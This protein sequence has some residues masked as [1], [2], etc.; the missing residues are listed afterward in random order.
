MTTAANGWGAR[1]ASQASELV[2]LRRE[3]DE[4]NRGVLALFAEVDA[5]FRTLYAKAPSGICLLD[6]EGRFTDANPAL[7]R[8]LRLDLA[9]VIGKRF[10]DVAPPD[11]I[12]W[13]VSPLAEAGMSMA[14][15][16]DVSQRVS[17]EKTR[18]ELLAREQAA[19]REAERVSL[20]KDDLIA[21]LSHELRTPLNAIMGWTHVLLR[22]GGNEDMQRGLQAIER[23]GKA[24][25]RLISDILDVSS[26]NLGKLHL[27]LEPC[28]PGALVRSALEEMRGPVADGRIEL[29]TTLNSAYRPIRADPGRI[30]QIVW[31]LVSNAIKFCSPGGRIE[32]SLVETERE[33]QLSVADDGQGIDPRFLP[34]LFDRFSQG[35]AASTRSR[36]GLGLGLS[37]VRHLVQLHHGTISASSP[38]I[39]FGSK[40]EI[41]LPALLGPDSAGPDDSTPG[42]PAEPTDVLPAK[43]LQGLKILV[44][45]DDEDALAI[46]QIILSD[47]GAQVEVARSCDEALRRFASFGPAVLLS[48]V[49][50]PGKDGHELLREVRLREA[51]GQHVSAIALTSFAREQ[52]VAQALAAGFDA[53]SAKPLRPL[54]LVHL[55][56]ELA[57]R[58][59]RPPPDVL[60][61]RHVGA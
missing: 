31:N 3:L 56:S 5:K 9:A 48:D 17:T 25:A 27:S 53:H 33:L 39:G 16:T 8:L 10:S 54:E 22:L 32:V 42:P 6:A 50:M 2:A 24:Q 45:D 61:P 58:H 23:N 34:H 20:L 15:A 14:V 44:V 40:F 29:L 35:D 30:Q 13:S 51:A 47:R 12:E 60:E 38:G 28:D 21:V 46:L 52:D 49:G 4:T 55:I 59:Q 11:C 41:R 26:I 37:I 57:R 43:L 7:L 1:V 19:R 36:G 18:V